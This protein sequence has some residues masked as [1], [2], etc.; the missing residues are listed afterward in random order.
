MENKDNATVFE[1][2]LANRRSDIATFRKQTQAS[3]S[4]SLWLGITVFFIASG[5]TAWIAIET[6]YDAPKAIY[7]CS[8]GK[9]NTG[10]PYCSG[11]EN[12][13]A[14][15]YAFLAVAAIAFG[16][17]MLLIRSYVSAAKQ[18]ASFQRELITMKDIEV[19]FEIS[20]TLP[21]ELVKQ[22]M[23]KEKRGDDDDG[24]NIKSDKLF[25]KV[26][27]QQQ[28]IETLLSKYSI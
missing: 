5:L 3:A 15:T 28:I 18:E 1:N 24:K 20:K 8:H 12:Y 11:Y 19:A 17:S 9:N 2:I 6:R 16:I 10:Q 13:D 4:L 23:I 27:A 22:E 7:K 21:D 26:K 25:P 14:S